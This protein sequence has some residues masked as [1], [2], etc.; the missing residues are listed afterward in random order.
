[1]P[2]ER[3]GKGHSL[4]FFL[5]FICPFCAAQGFPS[6]SRMDNRDSGFRQY[7]SDV[8]NARR[9]LRNNTISVEEAAEH[10][11]IYRYVPGDDE[12]IFSVAAR[13][14]V[15]YSAIVSLNRINNPA[16]L[17][18]GKEL[19]L[20]SCPGLFISQA[21]ESDLE[22]LLAAS[23]MANEKYININIR[24]A[25]TA[26]VFHFFPGADFSRTERTYFLNSGFRFPLQTFQ[27][28]SRY[29]LRQNP[30]T[31]NIVMHQGLDLAADAG[32]A[33]YAAADGIVTEIGEDP[34]YG[35]F[36]IITHS[37]RWSSLYGH[38]QNVEILL[39]S[40]VKSGSLIGRVGSTG[41]STGPHLHFEL[42]QDGKP[43]DPAGRLRP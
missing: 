28:T 38:L 37:E 29:G 30:V 6:I 39:R 18:S 2:K 20:P 11:T 31:G 3:T 7:I 9:R 22:K 4:A 27:L 36:I 5:I 19:L 43:L 41:Q 25:E 26:V 23:R 14:N 13:C 1:M 34:I 10:L 15:P 17:E 32:T 42:R 8:E 21:A 40:K 35:I 12:D 24:T 16:A 33:V